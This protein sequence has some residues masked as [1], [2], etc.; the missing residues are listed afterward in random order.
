MEGLDYLVPPMQDAFHRAF[1]RLMYIKSVFF[2]LEVTGANT[3]NGLSSIF[4]KPELKNKQM[5]EILKYAY[6]GD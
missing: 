3:R 1:L 6:L 5:N 4:H 2:W